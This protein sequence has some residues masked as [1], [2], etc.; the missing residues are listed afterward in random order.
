MSKQADAWLG[1]LGHQHPWANDTAPMILPIPELVVQ[2]LEIWVAWS[3][4][5]QPNEVMA[6]SFQHTILVSLCT[7]EIVY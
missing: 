7:S 2:I 4:N 1:W 6:Y 3:Q 5:K